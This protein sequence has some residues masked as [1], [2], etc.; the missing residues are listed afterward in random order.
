M[1]VGRR[2][3]VMVLSMATRLATPADAPV[4][5]RMEPAG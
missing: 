3:A 4:I 2:R 1:V 5:T